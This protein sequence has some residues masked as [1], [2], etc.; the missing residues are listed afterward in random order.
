MCNLNTHI[1]FLK[2]LCYNYLGSDIMKKQN[3]YFILAPIGV[4]LCA[5]AAILAYLKMINTVD[6]DAIKFKKEYESLNGEEASSE[7]VYKE[8]SISKN[9]PVKYAT[10]DELIDVIENGTGVIYLGFPGCPWCRTALPV[11]FDVLEKNNVKTLYYL[12]ILNERD[13][14]VVVDGELTYQLDDDGNEIKGTE[15]YHKLLEALDENLTDYIISYE[16]E[17]YE[18]G[19]KRIYAPTVIF[20]RNGKV[21]G[22]HVSTVESQLSGYDPITQEQYEELFTIYEDYVVE[23][24]SETCSTDSAC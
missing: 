6:T 15:G 11:L 13:S 3:L 9:N 24:N 2:K 1:L 19:E 5:V 16:G 10:Y 14:Y 8:I 20:V 18:T 17:T 12:N 23:M 7:K 21:I 22:L 4:V